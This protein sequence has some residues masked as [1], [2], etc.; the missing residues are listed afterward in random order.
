MVIGGTSLSGGVG[1]IGGTIQSALMMG[2]LN[3]EL[4]LLNVSSCYQLLVKGV[5]IVGAMRLDQ[6]GRR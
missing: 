4:D 1:G 5:I 6:R 2:V 3:N